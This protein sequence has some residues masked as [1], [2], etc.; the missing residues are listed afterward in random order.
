MEDFDENLFL[1]V[2]QD[3]KR[4]IS[5]RQNDLIRRSQVGKE[6]IRLVSTVS[7]SKSSNAILE[8]QREA[9]KTSPTLCNDHD[10]FARAA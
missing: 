7:L 4:L 5:S 10:Y 2:P 9:A 6:K 8:A 1:F 3:R